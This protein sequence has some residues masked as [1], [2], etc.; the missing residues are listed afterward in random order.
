MYVCLFTVCLFTMYVCLPSQD[1]ELQGYIRVEEMFSV[2]KCEEDGPRDSKYR[3]CFEVN[4]RG[5]GY[6]FAAETAE[7][8]DDWIESFNKIV[9]SD[10]AD[11]LVS[12]GHLQAT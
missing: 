7:E 10:T 5:R 8:L 4:T 11:N 2:A 1:S 3:Y 12:G 9:N 6:L